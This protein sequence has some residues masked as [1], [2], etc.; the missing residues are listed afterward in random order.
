MI[1]DENYEGLIYFMI[2][3][4][5]IFIFILF[6]IKFMSKCFGNAYNIYGHLS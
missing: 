2:N 3:H 6:Y 1:L 5:K 4:Y